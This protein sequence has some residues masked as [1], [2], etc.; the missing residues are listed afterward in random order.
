M[1]VTE[2]LSPHFA[3]SEFHCHDGTRV[4]SGTVSLLR[5]DLVRQVLEPLRAEFGSCRVLSGYRDRAYNARI[6]GAPDSRHIYIADAHRGLA[7]DV[8]FARGTLGEWCES[9]SHLL[10]RLGWGGGVGYYP[11]AHFMH[12]DSRRVRSRWSG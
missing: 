12:V 4:P 8:V 7:S 10:D 11:L 3:L 5:R 9:A 1:N 2:R 6:G